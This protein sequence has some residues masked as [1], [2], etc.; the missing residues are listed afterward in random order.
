VLQQKCYHI[1]KP[2]ISKD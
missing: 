2:W 1:I